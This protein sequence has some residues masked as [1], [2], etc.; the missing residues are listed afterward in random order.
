MFEQSTER[1]VSNQNAVNGAAI[2]RTNFI[3]KRNQQCRGI[4]KIKKRQYSLAWSSSYK[5][6]AILHPA[7]QR[8]TDMI[9][10]HHPSPLPPPLQGLKNCG[11]PVA[12][13]S[14]YKKRLGGKETRGWEPA[15]YKHNY[16]NNMK[17]KL[18]CLCT[19]KS[20]AT[21]DTSCEFPHC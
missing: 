12:T 17:E 16:K 13:K 5:I 14:T 19:F 21:D 7:N 4:G 1:T 3:H 6:S 15:L 10:L 9:E 11:A 8:E 18:P 20:Q 2:T